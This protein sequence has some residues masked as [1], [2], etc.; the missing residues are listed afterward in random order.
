M[1]EDLT[2]E[3]RSL[4]AQIEAAGKWDYLI[5][6]LSIMTPSFIIMGL[7][8]H[9]DSAPTIVI[10]MIL[11]ALF[12]LRTPLHHANILPIMKSMIQKLKTG[13]ENRQ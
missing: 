4:L 13:S 7:G 6:D 10:G 3:E 2:R 5:H 12:S 9:F 1:N 8:I 11:Y